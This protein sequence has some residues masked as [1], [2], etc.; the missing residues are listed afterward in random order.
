MRFTPLGAAAGRPKPINPMTVLGYLADAGGS[1][2]C[3]QGGRWL[4]RPPH[5]PPHP[6]AIARCSQYHPM[7]ASHAWRSLSL[8]PMQACRWT[9]R[10]WCLRR[11]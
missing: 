10:G 11:R 2:G 6:A 5:N 1:G 7:F 8:P 3:W 9:G 4:L